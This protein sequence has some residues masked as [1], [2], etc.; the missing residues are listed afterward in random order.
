MSQPGTRESSTPGHQR[1]D[2]EIGQYLCSF[3]YH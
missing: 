3:D 1:L 2:A